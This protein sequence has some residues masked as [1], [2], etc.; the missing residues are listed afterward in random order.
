MGVAQLS[1]VSFYIHTYTYTFMHGHHINTHVGT[2][3]ACPRAF[4]C[5]HYIYIYT[6]HIPMFMCTQKL[7]IHAHTYMHAWC[8][9]K[10]A[11]IHCSSLVLLSVY[12]SSTSMDTEPEAL[13]P[14]HIYPGSIRATSAHFTMIGSHHPTP[15]A[16]CS[17]ILS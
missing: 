2:T 6:V 8:D 16:H 15:S 3:H 1:C 17:C 10:K 4:V 11:S 9:Q 5:N 12:G 13:S 14:D 7:H